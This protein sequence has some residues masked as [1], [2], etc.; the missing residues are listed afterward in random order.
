MNM[1]AMN[2][3]TH[4][5]AWTAGAMIFAAAFALRAPLRGRFAFYWDSAQFALS[6][7]HYDLARSLPHPPGY[8]L[9]VMLGRIVNVFLHEPHTA[10]L[11]MSVVFG[12]ALPVALFAL[13][14]VMFSRPVGWMAAA[15]GAT[16]LIPW[17][18]SVIVYTYVVDGFYVTMFAL[19]CWR[20]RARGV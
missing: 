14:R 11:W 7:E 6:L 16:S 13:G 8:F 9:Y 4:R 17:F 18:Y 15:I 3:R 20:A 5:G 10:L 19:M 1:P 12:S 2:S